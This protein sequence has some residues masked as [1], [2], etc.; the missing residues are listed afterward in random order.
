MYLYAEGVRNGGMI[1]KRKMIVVL[2]AW[3]FPALLSMWFGT[4]QEVPA[5]VKMLTIAMMCAL[6]TAFVFYTAIQNRVE[7]E[8]LHKKHY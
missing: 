3:L 1:G 2:A 7:A 5:Q 8:M 4:L 6:V